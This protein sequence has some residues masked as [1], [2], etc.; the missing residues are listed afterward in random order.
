MAKG[1]KG[2]AGRQN[3]PDYQ[4]MAAQRTAAANA[5][6]LQA[7]TQANRPSPMG[8]QGAPDQNAW[9][10]RRRMGGQMPNQGDPAAAQ[11]RYGQ[12]FAQNMGNFNPQ[13]M[14]QFT[15]SPQFQQAMALRQQQ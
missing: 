14:Q 2:G 11:A 15:S 5:N 1:K 7:Q 13:Q 6:T 9:L 8:G 12:Q 4:G 10:Q 3:A